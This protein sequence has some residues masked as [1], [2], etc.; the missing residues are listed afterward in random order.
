MAYRIAHTA[1]STPL[2][3]KP[4]EYLT[5]VGIQELNELNIF[6][7]AKEGFAVKDA[8]A[9]VS[10]S[11]LYLSLRVIER[12]V[13]KPGRRKKGKGGEFDTD[14]LS[15][16][17]SAIAFQYAKVLED[18]MSVFGTLRLAEEWLAKPCRHLAGNI[19]L[20]LVSN[21]LG[22]QVVENYLERLELGV[23]Q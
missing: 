9:M 23:Y 8:E 14:R 5:H 12:I 10:L 1:V 18:A 15:V 7:L 22:F 3:R 19:P 13:G 21:P 20:D 16:L 17:Q 6:L 11:E 2:V 4:T